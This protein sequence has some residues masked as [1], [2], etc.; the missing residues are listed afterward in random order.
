MARVDRRELV[1]CHVLSPTVMPAVD[2]YVSPAVYQRILDG[3]RD[4]AR[5]RLAALVVR[6]RRAGVRARGVLVEGTPF[7][8][9][10]RVARAERADLVV[11]GTHGRTG[12]GRFFLGS[13]A[14]RVVA[15]SPVPVLTVRGR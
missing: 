15:T 6:A 8:R 14:E 4:G 9:I 11:M 13:V 5:T 2:G 12:L 1:I 10:V 7:D 3:A